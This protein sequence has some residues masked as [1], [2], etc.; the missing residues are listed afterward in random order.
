MH[1]AQLKTTTRNFYMPNQINQ[2]NQEPTQPT[3]RTRP[4]S[5]IRNK[6]SISAPMPSSTQESRGTKRRYLPADERKQEILEAAFKEFA[7]HGFVATSLERIAR[8]AGI[9]KSGIYAHYKSKDEIFEKV[10][11]MTLFSADSRNADSTAVADMDLCSLI[12]HHLDRR[13]E[14]LQSPRAIAAFRLLVAESARAPK[15][16]RACVRKLIERNIEADMNFLQLIIPKGH[17]LETITQSQHLLNQIPIGAWL[18]M[19]TIFGEHEAPID[20][21]AFK[22]IHRKLLL[23]ELQQ[24]F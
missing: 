14:Y 1:L 4:S 10:L 9:S 15:M 21:T 16:V 19:K 6:A 17:T 23:D 7:E 12:D 3:D 5:P 11:L 22:D 2:M 18:I 24:Y 8:Q 13:Y 20:V